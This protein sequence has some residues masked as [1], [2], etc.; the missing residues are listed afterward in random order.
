[1][2]EGA[3]QLPSGRRAT[4]MPDPALPLN[5]KPAF[6]MV[7]MA[8]PGVST[9][10]FWARTVREVNPQNNS[11]GHLNAPNGVAMHCDDWA[12]WVEPSATRHIPKT[13][14]QAFK[15]IWRS[16]R[17]RMRRVRGAQHVLAQAIIEHAARAREYPLLDHTWHGH[18]LEHAQP[19]R[20]DDASQT[21]HPQTRTASAWRDTQLL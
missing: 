1:M 10:Q 11:R 21:A 3:L 7:K 9:V 8:R 4:T 17:Q 2:H 6:K 16:P 18:S 13:C 20:K 14:L 19:G 12:A 15:D 5:M